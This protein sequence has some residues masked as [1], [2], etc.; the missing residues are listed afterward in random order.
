MRRGGGVV[1]KDTLLGIVMAIF[2]V[3]ML[4]QSKQ[5]VNENKFDTIGPS[6]FPEGVSW[7][8]LG[9]SIVLIL[10]SLLKRSVSSPKV[11][12]INWNVIFSFVILFAYIILLPY[13]GFILATFI[14]LWILQVFLT[15]IRTLNSFLKITLISVIFSLVTFLLFEKVLQVFLPRFDLFL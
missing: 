9:L 12:K 1:K 11:T 3:G 5:L 6:G 2:S 13:L 15:R 4:I 7:I 10:T 8:L 14:F